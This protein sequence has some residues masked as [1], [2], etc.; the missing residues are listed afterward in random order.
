[1][2][3]VMAEVGKHDFILCLLNQVIYRTDSYGNQKVDSGGGVAKL[4]WSL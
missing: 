4:L 1:M 3:P 2:N